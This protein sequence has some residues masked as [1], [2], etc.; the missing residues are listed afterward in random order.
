MFEVAGTDWC[1]PTL[2]RDDPNP[3]ASGHTI[4]DNAIIHAD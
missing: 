1:D 4:V 3:V 2:D